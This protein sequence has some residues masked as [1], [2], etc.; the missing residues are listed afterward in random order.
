MSTKGLPYL[1]N[2]YVTLTTDSDEV[3]SIN[4]RECGLQ[5]EEESM[6]SPAAGV[7]DSEPTTGDGPVKSDAAPDM[8]AEIYTV[9]ELD[10]NDGNDTTIGGS[11][12][13]HRFLKGQP[14][15]MGIIVLTLG[16]SFFIISSAFSTLQRSQLL[17]GFFPHDLLM[18]TLFIISGI[19]YI[20][21]EHN[22]TKK[23]VT[24]SLA[25]SI[26]S[27]LGVCWTLVQIV[28][29]VAFYRGRF[30]LDEILSEADILWMP[31]FAIMTMTVDAVIVFYSLTGAVILIVMSVLAGAALRSTKSQVTVMM[32]G[33]S[34]ETP[35]E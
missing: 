16:S 27:L 24:I 14:K 2:S 10:G 15:I 33:A 30:F 20:L 7:V 11:K 12:P 9:T 8:S 26:V 5:C 19:L 32:T 17:W 25:L 18:G 6:D 34:T 13:L 31:Y 28:P 29:Y 4:R 1:F 3:F 23:T 22:P 21:T 35:A